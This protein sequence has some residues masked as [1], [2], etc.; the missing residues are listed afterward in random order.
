MI[1]NVF[2]V[3]TASPYKIFP[4]ECFF[5]YFLIS[6]L[7]TWRYLFNYKSYSVFE[8]EDL[9]NFISKASMIQ[10]QSLDRKKIENPHKYYLGIIE[11][12]ADH[13]PGV[14]FEYK[15]QVRVRNSEDYLD[16][17]K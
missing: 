17:S 14:Y 2:A 16:L 13:Y 6:I 4:K 9:Y 11:F 7:V 12:Y 10:K 3:L 15:M 8:F 1:I 5:I